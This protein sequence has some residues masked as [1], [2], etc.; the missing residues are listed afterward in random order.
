MFN[1]IMIILLFILIG[2]TTP[3]LGAIVGYRIV[4][5]PS[6]MFLLVYFYDRDK[7]LI[8]FPFLNRFK[9]TKP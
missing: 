8:K 7:V 5:L 3:I 1:A 4:A 6:L 2:L 9:S